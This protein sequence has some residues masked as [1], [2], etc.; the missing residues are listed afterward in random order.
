MKDKQFCFCSAMLALM[1][2][3]VSCSQATTTK[4][5]LLRRIVPEPQVVE[6]LRAESFKL[7]P[8]EIVL[9]YGKSSPKTKLGA[10]EINKELN[11]LGLTGRMKVVSDADYVRGDEKLRV[12]IGSDK[13][14]SVAKKMW[15]KVKNREELGKMNF[16]GYI[17]DFVKGEKIATVVLAGETPQGS[18]YGC[19][20]FMQMLDTEGEEVIVQPVYVKDW[21]DLKWRNLG[22]PCHYL[23]WTELAL[24]EA[25]PK[26]P[27]PG[28][29]ERGEMYIDW[30][31]RYKMNIL[32]FMP[33]F[34]WKVLEAE[35]NE[36]NAG[37]VTGD[38]TS[39]PEL[40]WDK[41]EKA[42]EKLR[43]VLAYGRE[44]GIMSLFAEDVPTQAVGFRRNWEEFDKIKDDPKYKGLT[45]LSPDFRPY[46][47]FI[48]WSREDLLE[49]KFRK[50]AKQCG[51]LGV[52]FVWYHA[53]DTGLG[54]F[55]YAK[56]KDRDE[57]DKKKWGNDYGRADAHIMNMIHR[58]FKEESPQTR[59]VFITYPYGASVF[60][61]D[62]PHN[63]LQVRGKTID[64]AGGKRER[65]FI[66]NY[67]KTLDELTPKDTFF[68][69]RECARD[70]MERWIKFTNRPVMLANWDHLEF[71]NSR[72]RYIHSWVM[73]EYDNFY[74]WAGVYDYTYIQ[75]YTMP[76]RFLL[77][78][79][80]S[81][82]SSQS[83]YTDY[84]H[85]DYSKDY[86]EPKA[87]F[88]EVIPRTCRA[89]WGDETGKY[90][91]PL[92]QGQLTPTF[93]DDPQLFFR[94]V[95]RR[96][97][98]G[99]VMEQE[100]NV[101]FTKGQQ[102]YS[103]PIKEMKRQAEYLESIQPSLEKWFENYPVRERDMINYQEGMFLY[104]LG[105][106]WNLKAKAWIP[107]LE[108]QQAINKGQQD[109]VSSLKAQCRDAISSGKKQMQDIVKK[110]AEYPCFTPYRRGVPFNEKVVKDF[111]KIAKQL[112]E[113]TK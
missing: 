113:L 35:Q 28:M 103:E 1:L 91:A 61:D 46:R 44:R 72:P 50:F 62:F 81:W 25:F 57:A 20:T 45:N 79:E 86:L 18:L 11:R 32:H 39:R 42:M 82:H 55:N 8:S 109:Q 31:L 74:F 36:T 19:I 65:D 59:I 51:R 64:E 71:P 17:V 107:Y 92:F 22:Y 73:K 94:K 3:S 76:V 112:E 98:F 95:L 33:W 2:A 87:V 27:A 47:H 63:M 68:L 97:D 5:Q 83:G 7:Q 4:Q 12:V 88:D 93:L 38:F 16:E 69:L 70:D 43:Q 24:K 77:H 67:F 37:Y 96:Q 80:Y 102:R 30:M 89:L 111:D 104:M 26:G 101:V 90:L 41:D 29:V 75:F 9:V 58:I 60:S 40:D 49:P 110:I 52:E 106:Y 100:G 56:W 53:V 48:T 85:S 54:S 13:E 84:L 99:K 108:L 34:N 14:N 15:G 66:R 6:V 23:Y 10:E 21:P 78:S 105:N